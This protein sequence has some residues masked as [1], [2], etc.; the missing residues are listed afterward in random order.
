MEEQTMFVVKFPKSIGSQDV[1]AVWSFGVT[2]QLSINN[3]LS[4]QAS[5]HTWQEK[6]DLGYH[7]TRVTVREVE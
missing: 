1:Y 7:C 5:E 6:Q 4:G 3:Y 2:E